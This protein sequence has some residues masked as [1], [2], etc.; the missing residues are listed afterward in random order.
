MLRNNIE[1]TILIILC[2]AVIGL[3]TFTGCNFD[4]KRGLS[5]SDP[6]ANSSVHDKE[7]AAREAQLLKDKDAGLFV[8]V[9][10]FNHVPESYEPEDLAQ[11]THCA[12]GRDPSTQFMRREAVE[13]FNRM[14][15]A[16]AAENI[17]IVMTTAY[18]SHGFQ[19]VL[20]THNVLVKG[21]EAEA[22]KTSA[23]PDES[24][25][26]TG[27]AV[28]IS[29]KSVNYEVTV[30][31]ENT[32][33]GKWVQEHAHEYG[34]IIRYPKEKADVTGYSYEAWHLR[35][36]GITAAEDIY[37]K[38][39]TLEEYLKET[40][41]AT[42]LNGDAAVFVNENKFMSDKAADDSEVVDAP[43]NTTAV[44]SDESG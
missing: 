27:L 33:A 5:S 16:A 40:G 9:N 32:D 3:C 2:I 34:F 20:W 1:K 36:V 17:E 4:G 11:M 13:S 41:M 8:L 14:V 28:D 23:R 22:N 37:S 21:S 12:E 39:I 29:T 26:R 7:A 24:E 42:T 31:F 18:R 19:N 15:E 25:H 43:I 38:G 10:K 30:N 35:Y 44:N 6:S